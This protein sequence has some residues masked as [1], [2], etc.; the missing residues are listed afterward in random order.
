MFF[1][2]VDNNFNA[3]AVSFA[4]FFLVARICINPEYGQIKSH[5]LCV[6]EVK[7]YHMVIWSLHKI[8]LYDF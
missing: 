4:M 1:S 2:I 5:F 3:V 6:N 7:H 8:L